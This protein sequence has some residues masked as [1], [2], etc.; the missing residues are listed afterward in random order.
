MTMANTTFANSRFKSSMKREDW[1][2]RK[3]EAKAGQFVLQRF[4]CDF[5]TR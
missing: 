1:L 2:G 3:R 4:S 5:G